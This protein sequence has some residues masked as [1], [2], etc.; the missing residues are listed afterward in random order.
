MYNNSLSVSSHRKKTK[1]N[2]NGLIG[3][4]VTIS[5]KDL[6]Y[7]SEK[8]SATYV[9]LPKDVLLYPYLSC[10]NWYIFRRVLGT[11]GDLNLHLSIQCLPAIFLLHVVMYLLPVQT[12]MSE[13]ISG[14]PGIMM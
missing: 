2:Y 6:F 11:A 9:S 3:K 1:T 13:G 12:S 4:S 8:G 14:G 7:F 5:Q 10:Y